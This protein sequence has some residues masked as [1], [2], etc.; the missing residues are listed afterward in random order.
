VA[1]SSVLALPCLQKCALVKN[2]AYFFTFR[3]SATDATTPAIHDVLIGCQGAKGSG[4]AILYVIYM[5]YFMEHAMRQ[6]RQVKSHTSVLPQDYGMNP[7]G[8]LPSGRFGS[9]DSWNAC[10]MQ[11]KQ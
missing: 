3:D 11:H 9:K 2:A 6:E 1:L 5:Q 8:R 4:H 10:T 7:S